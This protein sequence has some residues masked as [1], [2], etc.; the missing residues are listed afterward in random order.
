MWYWLND[1]G[2]QI[3]E[4][5]RLSSNIWKINSIKSEDCIRKKSVGS[6]KTTAMS[7]KVT[8]H[9]YTDQLWTG[10]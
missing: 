10:S 9:F 3:R 7:I 2:M 4:S 5:I 8:F 6:N 1:V